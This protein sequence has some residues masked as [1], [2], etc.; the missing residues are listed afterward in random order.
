MTENC[1]PCLRFPEFLKKDWNVYPISKFLQESQIEGNRGNIA[2]KLT[3]KLWGKGVIEKKENYSGSIATRYFKRKSGQF[4]YSKLDFLNQA[5]GI[6]PDHLDGF[7]STVDLPC[8]DFKNSIVP[9]FF[10]NYVMRPIFYKKNGEVADGGRKAKRIQEDIFLKFSIAVPSPSEQQKIADCLSS[11]DELIE[12][13]EQKCEALK[14]HKKGLMQRLFPAEGET[15]PRW[16]FPEFR[17]AGEWKNEIV[18]NM[19]KTF[20]G[21]TPSTT[22]KEYYG[23]NIPFIRSAEINKAKTEL[24]ITDLGVKNSSAKLVHK[25]DIL[26][27]LYGANSGEIAISK[28]DGAINQAI[29]C[30]RSDQNDIFIFYYLFFKKEYVISKYLQGGQGNLSG[31][32]VKSIDI[33]YPSPPEQQKIADCLSSLDERIEAQEAKTAALREHKKGLMQRLFPRCL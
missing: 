17:D 7:E 6:I 28:I 23:G 20:S 32:I 33:Y 2:K 1:T 18:G 10:L 12:A 21:G 19:C 25:G 22:K 24:Y 14:Q 30:I 27:A 16:R 26:L 13:H 4:I 15:M 31:E 29:L 11:L 3:V 9:L 8:F 5:F